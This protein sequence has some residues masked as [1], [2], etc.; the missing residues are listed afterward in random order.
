MGCCCK[1]RA[2][3]INM[4]MNI[5]VNSE[6]FIDK[7]DL[8][9]GKKVVSLDDFDILKLIGKG[10]FSK[11]YLVKNRLNHK[12]YSMK[13][14]DK[15]FIKRTRQEQHII[16]ER[17]LLSKMNY[18]F[19]VKL[20]CCFQDQDHLYFILEF[21]QG[22]ELFFHLHREIRFDDEKTRFYIAELILVL[23]FLHNN[24]VIYRDIKP[25]NILLDLEGHIKLTD[26]GLSRLC[27][28]INEK[29]F[30]ICG[31]PYYI[32]PE[33]IENKGY[34]NSVDWWSL[35]CLM[36]EMLNG[37]PLFNFSS[38]K[39]DTN[40]F[41][42]EIVL[43]NNF[44]EEAKDLIIKLL[45]KNPKNRI[46][47]IEALKHPWI[48]KY[49]I[50]SNTTLNPNIKK[51]SLKNCLQTFSSKQKLHQASVAFIVHQMSNTKMV[52][53]LVNIFKELDESGEGLLSPEELKKG[54]NKYFSDNLNDKEFDEIMNT[55][56]QDKSGQI[57]IEEFLRAT[58]NYEN[59]VTEKNLK[60]A[61]DYFDKDHSGYLS[62]DEIKE[63]L[64]LN[65]NSEETMKLV[66]IL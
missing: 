28:G 58:I 51:L 21:I 61:F 46:T 13:K 29:V 43:P 41:K 5:V 59:L 8:D 49:S 10:S 65:D 44:S 9:E 1:K 18:P 39:I 24:K 17:I 23:N 42:K 66:M 7:K 47:A 45:E 60:Y 16:N 15:P 3:E 48:V 54:Y 33:I 19:L 12:I 40:E 34:N 20:F 4:S 52:E 36:Y 27:S 38:G 25:E 55:I 22:G 53:D 30:T 31:T 35:G 26:F 37:K 63:V 6:H 57:S 11:V 62:P 32:A 64:G 2:E 56:D 50:K 14:L